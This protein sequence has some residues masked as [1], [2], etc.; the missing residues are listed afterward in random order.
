MQFK[1]YAAYIN[2]A[3]ISRGLTPV[4]TAEKA[5]LAVF[6]I[7]GIGNPQEHQYSYSLPVWG[8]TG[9]SSSNTYGTLSMYGNYGT[10]SGTT[11]YNPTY[12]IKGYTSHVGNYATY[13]RFLVL[14]ALDLAEYKQTKKEVQ[15][16][17]TII[18]STGSSGD[19]RRV[20]PYLV[21]A[22]KPHIAANTGQQIKV[23]LEENDPSVM[24]IKGQAPADQKK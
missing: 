18:T 8:Q 13:F 11:T 7:Y 9:V 16:W 12:G 14:D 21:S 22:S 15:L 17:K 19:L 24:E 10:Y 23:I 2:R 4:E 3:L 1:E 20:F 5:D 6:V